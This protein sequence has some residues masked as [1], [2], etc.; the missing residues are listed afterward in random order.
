MV[1]ADNS[2]SQSQH[3]CLL[4]N[5]ARIMDLLWDGSKPTACFILSEEDRVACGKVDD[6]MVLTARMVLQGLLS[7]SWRS[8]SLSADSAVRCCAAYHQANSSGLEHSVLWKK[9]PLV[10]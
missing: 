8:W 1:K 9:S 6:I 4:H 3:Q 5:K 10:H 2:Q 7:S